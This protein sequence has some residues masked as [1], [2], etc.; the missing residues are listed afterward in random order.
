MFGVSCGFLYLYLFSYVL[1]HCGVDWLV[2]DWMGFVV[3]L[4]FLMCLCLVRG[5]GFG[6]LVCGFVC[7]V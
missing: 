6:L 4:L 2:L 7:V 1:L 3:I 5:F